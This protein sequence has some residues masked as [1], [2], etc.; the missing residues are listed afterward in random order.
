METTS[1]IGKRIRTYKKSYC[2]ESIEHHGQVL[3]LNGYFSALQHQDKSGQDFAKQLIA[4][5]KTV[6]FVQV[7]NPRLRGKTDLHGQPYKGSKFIFSN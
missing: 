4:Q 3:T 2:P 5:G 6:A 7:L 1:R